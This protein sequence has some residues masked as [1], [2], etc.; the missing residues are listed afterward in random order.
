MITPR[1]TI[2][3]TISQ[4]GAV[5]LTIMQNDEIIL[6]AESAA[7]FNQGA[8]PTYTGDYDV[9][10]TAD[11]EV[12]KTAQKTMSKDL[13]IH[14]IPYFEVSNT[15]GGDTVYIGGEIERS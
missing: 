6:T 8:A 11:G 14:P 9:T 12:L 5:P 3:L 15:A 10:P 7:G 4:Q 13:T 2:H 1:A